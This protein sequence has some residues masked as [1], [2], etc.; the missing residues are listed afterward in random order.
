MIE[1][2]KQRKLLSTLIKQWMSVSK[3][4]GPGITFEG[5]APPLGPPLAPP[6]ALA[7][8]H[9]LAQAQVLALEPP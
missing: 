5:R 2:E 9:P 7:L 4:E 1:I 3:G 8:G 6:L